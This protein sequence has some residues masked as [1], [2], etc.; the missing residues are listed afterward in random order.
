[1]AVPISYLKITGGETDAAAYRQA[2]QIAGKLVSGGLWDGKTPIRFDDVSR[3]H[4]KMAGLSD[5]ELSLFT[6]EDFAQRAP[7]S[8]D[9]APGEPDA[10]GDADERSPDV[11]PAPEEA[12]APE[13]AADSS[14]PGL[15]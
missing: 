15:I 6:L 10:D 4:K 9:A 12:A 3:A 13:L 5:K 8:E 2:V 7:M 1:M 14:Q 11:E